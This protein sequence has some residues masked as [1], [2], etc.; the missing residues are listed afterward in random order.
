MKR[1]PPIQTPRNPEYEVGSA[2]SEIWPVAE[3]GTAARHF[4]TDN[5][6]IRKTIAEYTLYLI[7]IG[8]I[9]LFGIAGVD[10]IANLN[11]FQD[12]LKN[13]PF[14]P[15]WSSW[16][17]A[18]AT[19]TSFFVINGLLLAGF[20]KPSMMRIGLWCATALLFVFTL[21]VAAIMTMAPYRPCICIGM[22]EKLGLDWGAH[23]LLNAALLALS[24]TT[25]L[26]HYAY[27]ILFA[28]SEAPSQ[29]LKNGKFQQERRY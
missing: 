6:H 21:Y 9:V 22:D 2:S 26:L 20:W 15:N 4:L 10:K 12:G 18:I 1:T 25:M 29:P 16:P 13:S 19:I 11:T 23:L 5:Q 3:D 14:I 28:L 24:W 27:K 7:A 17:T 8:F